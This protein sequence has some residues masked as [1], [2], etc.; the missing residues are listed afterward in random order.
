MFYFLK[1]FSIFLLSFYKMQNCI[2]RAIYSNNMHWCFYG[3]NLYL[4]LSS[5]LL[6]RLWLALSLYFYIALFLSASMMLWLYYFYDYVIDNANWHSEP[7]MFSELK[8]LFG[9]V[10]GPLPQ[11]SLQILS[12]L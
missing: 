12:V 2:A 4:T 6:Y 5:V 10:F 1:Y 11:F 8:I 7:L 3:R 9:G